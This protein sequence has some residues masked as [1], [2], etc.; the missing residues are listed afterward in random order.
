MSS[1]V[2][3]C[4]VTD[5]VHSRRAD[6]TANDARMESSPC[7]RIILHYFRASTEAVQRQWDECAARPSKHI[8]EG[9]FP[10]SQRGALQK[11][12]F[13]RISRRFPGRDL[14]GLGTELQV[15]RA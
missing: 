13:E 8:N 3:C 4:A 6:K 1:V 2:L 15:A 9:T 14:P 12:V 7:L 11:E 5:T 10:A